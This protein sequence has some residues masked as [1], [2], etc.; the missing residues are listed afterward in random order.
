MSQ[1][2]DKIVL[3]LCTGNYYRSAQSHLPTKSHLSISAGVAAIPGLVA[4]RRRAFGARVQYFG[5]PKL[6]LLKQTQLYLNLAKHGRVADRLEE[7]AE[8]GHIDGRPDKFHIRLGA[9]AD[10]FV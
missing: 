5:L 8:H 3:F 2:R 7:L 6:A 1:R 9:V 4:V 10:A